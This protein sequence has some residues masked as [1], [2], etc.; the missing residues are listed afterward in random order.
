MLGRVTGIVVKV[1]V[2]KCR[3]VDLG[4]CLQPE[5]RPKARWAWWQPGFLR[6]AEFPRRH[7][8]ALVG[9]FVVHSPIEIAYRWFLCTLDFCPALALMTI[10]LDRPPGCPHRGQPGGL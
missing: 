6:Y 9:I 4:K 1:G 10:L 5:S 2:S 8:V 3:P 7:N